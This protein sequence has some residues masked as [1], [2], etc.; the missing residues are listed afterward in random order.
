MRAER[1]VVERALHPLRSIRFV[2]MEY[3]GSHGNSTR[4]VSLEEV[5]R[6]QIYVG[7]I[8]HRYG[9]GITEAEYR[10]AIE[11]RL[12]CLIYLKE[13]VTVHAEQ[14][15]ADVDRLTSLRTELETRHTVTRFRDGYDLA[16]HLVADLH[17]LVFDQ[18]ITQGISR[19]HG[20]YGS[21]I[22][23]FIAEYVGTIEAPVAF[24]GRE[25]E[26]GALNDWLTD[27]GSPPYAML[28][29]PAGRGKSALLVHWVQR[30]SLLPNVSLIYFPISIRFRTNMASIAFAA[31]TARL[32][33]LHGEILPA[34]QDTPPE[35]WR[36]LMSTYL[37][38]AV[39]DDH[40]FVMVLD[41]AD[42]SADWQFG[43]D[44]FPVIPP[45]GLR[46]I[47]SARYLAGDVDARG[48]MD[49]LGWTHNRSAFPLDLSSLTPQGLI[50][51]LKQ[52]SL[53]LDR[54]SNRIDIVAEL[55]RL[56]NG[57]P[58]LVNLYVADLWAKGEEVARLKPEDLSVLQPGLDGYF[59]RWWD[60]QR[61]LWGDQ[62]PLREPAANDIL[63]T[64]SCA[65]GPLFTAELLEMLPANSNI[66][67]WALDDI[68]RSL[69]RF[70]IGD[71]DM[72]GYTFSH[73]R[74]ADYFYDRLAKA[75]RARDQEARF[76]S[77]GLAS[78]KRIEH[79][80]CEAE[81]PAY[82]IHYL[83]PH[84]ERTGCNAEALI[85]LASNPWAIGWG[86]LERGSYTGFLADIARIREKLAQEDSLR[87]RQG[88]LLTLLGAEIRCA[89]YESSIATLEAEM[90]ICLVKAMMAKK[91]WSPEQAIAYVSRVPDPYKRLR[92]L[93]ELTAEITPSFRP[94]AVAASLSCI[95][96]QLNN[97]EGKAVLLDVLSGF[98]SVAN[99]NNSPAETAHIFEVVGKLAQQLPDPQLRSWLIDKL[100]LSA[101]TISG[102]PEQ[103]AAIFLAL[104]PI[105]GDPV[106]DRLW[107]A[108]DDAILNLASSSAHDDISM[109][110]ERLSLLRSARNIQASQ[111][112]N[113]WLQKS[114][115]TALKVLTSCVMTGATKAEAVQQPLSV[116]WQFAPKA[117]VI[118]SLKSIAGSLDSRHLD[119]LLDDIAQWPWVD[120]RLDAMTILMGVAPV[121]MRVEIWQ[122]ITGRSRNGP[123]LETSLFRYFQ[124]LAEIQG[125]EECSAFI[126]EIGHTV[127]P[128]SK[129]LLCRTLTRYCRETPVPVRLAQL[130]LDVTL[131]LPTVDERLDAL[132]AILDWLNPLGSTDSFEP[133][134]P[135]K[136]RQLLAIPIRQLLSR[137][138]PAPMLVW[139][140]AQ[141]LASVLQ[142]QHEDCGFF[143]LPDRMTFT[144]TSFGSGSGSGFN[145]VGT[146]PLHDASAKWLIE[147]FL[148]NN[149]D[150]EE[151]AE[152]AMAIDPPL[153]FADTLLLISKVG[154][155]IPADTLR[156]AVAH[157]MSLYS[158]QQVFIDE[159]PS[160]LCRIPGI[161]ASGPLFPPESDT[162]KGLRILS[163]RLWSGA[164]TSP[165]L[166]HNLLYEQR[167]PDVVRQELFGTALT[168]QGGREKNL[169]GL[170]LAV[171]RFVE[172]SE[173]LIAKALFCLRGNHSLP[174]ETKV[175]I[176]VHLMPFLQ[177]SNLSHW[178]DEVVQMEP[179]TIRTILMQYEE[180]Q[181]LDET[182]F[183]RQIIDVIAQ[184]STSLRSRLIGNLTDLIPA[185]VVTDALAIIRKIDKE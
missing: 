61:T 93:F 178:L 11:R 52:M 167:M 86:Q 117:D 111:Y 160:E 35:V 20:D 41:G 80:E 180:S 37:H 142:A 48:W 72:Q 49:R 6:C 126:D 69:Q 110:A 90:S 129:I 73:P 144:A 96:D 15:E 13:G 28:A 116:C 146:E 24:G 44:L 170:L 141:S 105:L 122:V 47:V 3:F 133:W 164:D 176:I 50:D 99:Q 8:G 88:Q 74:L 98:S 174:K 68:M 4:D 161:L 150:A 29:G 166:L 77:W 182:S 26:L 66:E 134:R 123:L 2:G 12:P 56:T 58:L 30:L 32:A 75:G 109:A 27:P 63:N 155:S 54:L 85:R 7:I 137:V 177:R 17:N 175:Q 36:E 55:Y 138:K 19:L 78:L 165:E 172:P 145:D 76:V 163:Q 10:R 45:K 42:E 153:G 169:S 57:D 31:I 173:D 181:L 46:I 82:L 140:T 114:L 136:G 128:K 70:I 71:G 107:S 148:E 103:K 157:V 156:H 79:G 159:S 16:T 132:F 81:V 39:P 127:S 147:R 124:A 121:S 5:D 102:L 104:A 21:R 43:P 59:R 139:Q 113:T 152:T 23:R 131:Q 64:L 92:S 154:T 101:L 18:I 151:L 95:R 94:L 97:Q 162:L 120:D 108:H 62:S 87:A 40:R 168:L 118:A 185:S 33:E 34:G 184:Q 143:W 38:R 14:S 119:E 106:A 83:R 130:A 89:L 171:G 179:G 112:G 53:P 183:W 1:E 22:Q 25:A 91:I 149:Q 60:D 84:M 9:S 158:D 125:F 100:A 65:L 51:V 135:S 67:F 115:R